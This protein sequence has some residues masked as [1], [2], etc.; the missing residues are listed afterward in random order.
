VGSICETLV[1]K[2]CDSTKIV[3]ELVALQIYAGLR[4]NMLAFVVLF[5]I[6]RDL[7]SHRIEEI[8]LTLM[9]T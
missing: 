9:L 2:R 3:G 4:S 1:L 5:K 6:Q 7:E 8:I